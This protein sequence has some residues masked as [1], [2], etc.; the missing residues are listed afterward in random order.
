MEIICSNI[1]SLL[2]EN[3]LV[4]EMHLTLMDSLDPHRTPATP[5]NPRQCPK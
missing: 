1:L 2:F 3:N 5:K 4:I